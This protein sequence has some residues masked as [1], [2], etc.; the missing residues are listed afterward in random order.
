MIYLVD[1]TL[2]GDGA[3][4]REIAAALGLIAPDVPVVVDHHSRV[5]RAPAWTS[6][7][8]PTSS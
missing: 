7:D 3:S 1:N 5:T 2:D 4:P 6:S 8:R